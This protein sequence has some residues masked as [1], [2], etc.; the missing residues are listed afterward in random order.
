MTGMKKP[1]YLLAALGFAMASMGTT[2]QSAKSVESVP[3]ASVKQL[4]GEAPV[5]VE[6]ECVGAEAAHVCWL[7]FTDG[8]RCVVASNADGGDS[9]I[10]CHFST[11]LERLHRMPKD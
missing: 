4:P 3:A 9:A 7:K 1:L 11:P 8:T 2:A 5:A 10:N 6:R